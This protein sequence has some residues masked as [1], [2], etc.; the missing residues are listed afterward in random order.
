MR[1]IRRIA[2]YAV[3]TCSFGLTWLVAKLGRRPARGG[4]RR[5]GVVVTGTFYNYNWFL[6]HAKPLARSG[7]GDVV[8]VADEPLIAPPGVRVECPPR[9]LARIGGRAISKLIWMLVVG[10]R[11][12]PAVYMGYHL[13]PGALT[14]LIV[15]RILGRSA[16]YQMTGGPVEVL[17]G[18]CFN[19]NRLMSGLGR[20]SEFLERLAMAVVREFELV[21]V[22]GSNARRFLNERGLDGTI[23]IITG[24]TE[25]AEARPI[26]GRC[27]DLIFVGRLT[28]IKQADQFVSIVAAIARTRSMVRAAIVGEGPELESLRVQ[29][30]RMGVER[31]VE[32][33]GRRD[34]VMDLLSR[35]KVF[36]LTSRSEGLSIA[37]AE[38]MGCGVPAVVAD[39]GELGDLVRNGENGWLIPSGEI[40][41][42]AM[43]ILE[44]IGD[45]QRWN[46]YSRAAA[47]AAETL[48]S[49]DN[50]A[51]RWRDSLMRLAPAESVAT[52]GTEVRV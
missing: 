16:C 32:F 14:A 10:V 43:R 52:K 17:G 47:E 50:V 26:A 13:F 2:A 15:A 4:L 36:V 34:D 40:D 28:A 27:Y 5:S 48:T 6:S 12:R 21:V 7:F 8:F 30:A 49:V 38:A 51:R 23:E 35:S 1:V 45:E 3:L 42:Y 33:L 19:E 20:P 18:G 9:W 44:L 22:R 24:S 41:A 29:A 11:Q 37:L 25:P 46:H 39:V 31:N